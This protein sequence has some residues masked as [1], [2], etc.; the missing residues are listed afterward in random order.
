LRFLICFCIFDTGLW[1]HRP[2]V[3]MATQHVRRIDAAGC[4][5]G[6]AARPPHSPG[7]LWRWPRSTSVAFTRPAVAM[8]TQHVRRIH[9]RREPWRG[10]GRT[11]TPCVGVGFVSGSGISAVVAAPATDAT[12]RLRLSGRIAW[13]CVGARL[14]SYPTCVL[15]LPRPRSRVRLL[16][17]A[18]PFGP[19]ASLRAS[20]PRCCFICL[21]VFAAPAADKTL[22]LPFLGG[23]AMRFVEACL[24]AASMRSASF[25]APATDATLHFRL[26]GWI[27]MPS[28]EACLVAASMRS[29]IFAAPATHGKTHLRFP[30]GIAMRFVEACLVAASARSANF[31][32]PATHATP[33]RLRFPGWFA[34]RSVEACLVAAAMRFANFAVPAITHAFALPHATFSVRPVACKPASLL[35]PLRRCLC[36]ARARCNV[37][38][39]GS[40]WVCNAIW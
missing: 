30:G 10:S 12:L 11:A 21:A 35:I 14:V 1:M 40:R 9:S 36:R 24:V 32:A 27:A 37:A 17:R 38:S 18:P 16:F 7:R 33:L 20:P 5:D 31:A 23:A 4:G 13:L 29:A 22:H 15:S 39:S 8:A 3:A 25:A 28:V 2:A 34:M 19:V 26:P 6:H